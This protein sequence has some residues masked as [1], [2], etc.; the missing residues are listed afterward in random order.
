MSHV[1][2]RSKTQ[3]FSFKGALLSD[4]NTF[5]ILLFLIN[6]ALFSL[7]GLDFGTCVCRSLGR[8]PRLIGFGQGC[9][10]KYLSLSVSLS[11]SISISISLS[12]YVCIYLSVYLSIYL[13]VRQA[14]KTRSV[15]VDAGEASTRDSGASIVFARGQEPYADM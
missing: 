7:R 3:P 13:S 9:Q 6:S 2:A 11:L 12:I 4:P 10:Q 8:G 15:R 5:F 1:L 14:G